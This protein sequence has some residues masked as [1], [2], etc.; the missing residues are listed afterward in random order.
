MDNK[1]LITAIIIVAI[2]IIGGYFLLSKPVSSEPIKI[3][4]ILPLTGDLA[5][6]AE[7]M[8]NAIN[9]A[10]ENSGMQ[11]K[12]QVIFEDDHGCLPTDAVSAVQKLIN[13]DK[14]DALIG[15]VCTGS[16]LAVAPITE[17]KKMILLSPSSSSKSITN[18]GNYVYRVIASD[19]DKSVAVAKYAYDKGYKKAALIFDT[20]NDAFVQQ[21]EDVRETFIQQGGQIVAD[22][23]FI[24]TDKDF[25][26]QLT[27]IKQSD[28]EVIFIGALPKE[29]SLVIKQ[30]KDLG[31]KSIFV[32]TETSLGTQDT[33]DIAGTAANGLIFPFATTPD[34][35][36]HNDFINA[37]KAKYGIEP[38]AYAAE[39]YDAAMLLIKSLAINDRTP[40]NVKNEL[41]AIGQNYY[42]ASGIITFDENGDVQKPMIIKTIKDGQFVEVQ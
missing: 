19:A 4:A 6:Y 38:P 26:S 2:I 13:L 12:I 22:E 31:I 36:E 15:T 10:V 40:E 42:G 37:Y 23:S 16:T 7:G 34:N 41:Q 20:A 32:A 30:A 21:K 28:A 14:I 18:A 29:G 17:Q 11:D 24:T 5:T 39:G 33:I 3:G 35:K 9:L 25:R 8:R 1:K 27:K